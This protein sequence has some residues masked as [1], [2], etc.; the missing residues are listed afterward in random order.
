MKVQ[1][2]MIRPLTQTEIEEAMRMRGYKVPFI[3][4]HPTENELLEAQAL[5]EKGFKVVPKDETPR[6]VKASVEEW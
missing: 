6:K 5:I 4:H 3:I 1:T 2:K